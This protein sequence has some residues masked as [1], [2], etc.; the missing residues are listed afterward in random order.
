MGSEKVARGMVAATGKAAIDG[1]SWDVGQGRLTRFF[2]ERVALR[3]SIERAKLLRELYQQHTGLVDD[4]R[5]LELKLGE[6]E[7]LD[8]ILDDA[9]AE[10]R[11]RIERN[12]ERR[13]AEIFA[14][15]AQV[16]LAQLHKLKAERE[17]EQF[18]APPVEPPAPPPP[19]PPADPAAT[20]LLRLEEALRGIDR[21][22]LSD[23]RKEEMRDLTIAEFTV[24]LSTAFR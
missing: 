21:L 5:G 2:F 4:Q 16:T 13:Q 8:I 7:D 9:D 22:P 14:S 17:L 24:T 6:L 20:L 19:D 10:R 3:T 18:R 11:H 12:K 1:P 23:D 15:Q